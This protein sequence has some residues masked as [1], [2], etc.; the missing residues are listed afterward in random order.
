MPAKIRTIRGKTYG[1]ASKGPQSVLI[2]FNKS[3]N[4]KGDA[5]GIIY[6]KR[7]KCFTRMTIF[8][9]NNQDGKYNK[10]D[11]IYRSKTSKATVKE[12]ALGIREVK[13]RKQMHRCDWDIIKGK[14]PV[15]CTR[16]LVPTSYDLTLFTN[17]GSKV[18]PDPVGAFIDSFIELPE[19]AMNP[20][21]QPY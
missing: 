1:M 10:D 4:P 17:T 19:D 9:D 15:A 12:L 14:T 3:I 13:L 2:D 8:Q 6:F 5:Q 21:Y 11:I 18:R 20:V 16:D 7:G